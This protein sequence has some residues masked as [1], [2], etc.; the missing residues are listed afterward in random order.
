MS[1]LSKN[2]T[3]KLKMLACRIQFLGMLLLIGHTCTAQFTITGKVIDANSKEP[4]A[5]VTIVINEDENTG[6]YSDINGE[7]D[8]HSGTPI[9]SL[10]FSYV[11]YEKIKMEISQASTKPLLISMHESRIELREVIVKAGEN[12]ANRI[13]RKVIENK[14]I[15][16][17]D[18]II[19]YT[20]RSYNKVIY[21]AYGDTLND[22]EI[23]GDIDRVLRGGHLMI[24][25]SVTEK[26]Y[27]R[28]DN[29][30][31]IILG[32]KVSGFKHPSFA[33]LAT[34]LQ[35][36]SF[37]NDNI[38]IL[39]I[40]YLNPIANGSLSKYDFTLNDTLYQGKDTVFI[41]SYKPQAG[42]NF[43]GLTGLLYIHTNTYAIQNV[44]ARPEKPGFIDLN[45]RQQYQYVDQKQWFPQQLK[46]EL[47]T[48]ENP[49]MELGVRASG[50]SII[51]SV[52]LN[53]ELKKKDFSLES[54][55][56]DENA[57]QQDSIFWLENRASALN[58]KE[59]ITYQV[60]DS[61]GEEYKFDRLL[62]AMEALGRNRA[63]IAC[64]DLDISRFAGFNKYEGIRLG[65]GAYT[66]DELIKNFSVGGYWGYGFKDEAIKYG[67]EAIL[68]L[69]KAK[70]WQLS[71]KHQFDLRETGKSALNFF[72]AR[73]FDFR[74]YIA[75]QMDEVQQNS[76]SFNMR[77]LR[78][79]RVNVSLANAR[80]DPQYA[81]RFV[82]PEANPTTR[83]TNTELTIN[84]RYSFKEKLIQSMGQ[85]ISMGTKYPV[86]SLS[87]SRGLED[88]FS[89]QF[90]YNKYEARLDQSVYFRNF[91]E[92]KIRLNAG[93]IDQPL[94][95]GLLF[96]GEGS[97]IRNFS[98]LIKN[99][100]QTIAPYQ[101]VSD[102]YFSIHYSHNFNTLLFHIGNWKPS[103]TL[104]Q[105][106]GWGNLSH[107]EYH[108]DI[109]IQTKEKG[110]YETGLQLD[111]LI[112]FKYLNVS[113]L[114]LGAGAFYRY[115]PYNTGD[116]SEDLAFTFSVTFTT[117]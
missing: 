74:T 6:T 10:A 96:T 82:T 117:K 19:S 24:M 12:P 88:V 93:Y 103:I 11:G 111:N 35:P 8:Y 85:R 39:D 3:S 100:F 44:T 87:Y 65:L 42:K 13:I 21:D 67:G 83:Y 66:N 77:L 31:E 22:A 114:G 72:N 34:D 106:V 108:Q 54:I 99:T 49:D 41:L 18:N 36:F 86:L 89:G 29:H 78:Y 23:Q 69:D 60:V 1:E 62:K 102:E 109:E 26:K 25:E 113:Y 57:S 64:I 68:S 47:F 7:F 46:F 91:G 94:P 33:P 79:A 97:F 70:D 53:P 116:L 9:K 80:V 37:Y 58:R 17:P 110:L 112:R 43:E 16:N 76:G 61:L 38:P 73:Q 92:S 27:I 95:Y 2:S 105:N 63:A 48:T 55:R 71:V 40:T 75:S 51:D 56:L 30:E 101:Y 5:F 90:S 98:V 4:L 15:N 50:I 32:T 20:C 52:N 104:L 84:L 59:E 107:P 14:K 45:I 81:Y 115:G 28:P